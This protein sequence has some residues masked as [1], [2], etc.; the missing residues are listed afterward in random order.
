MRLFRRLHCACFVLTAGSRPIFG[1]GYPKNEH[2]TTSSEIIFISWPFPIENEEQI[3]LQHARIQFPISRQS[4][5]Q[6]FENT[7]GARKTSGRRFRVPVN[8]ANWG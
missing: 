8:I 3:I 1:Q 2:Y 4:V 7:S 6:L 5:R